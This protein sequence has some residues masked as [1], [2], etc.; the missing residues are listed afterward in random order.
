MSQLDLDPS[1][2]ETAEAPNGQARPLRLEITTNGASFSA[3]GDGD[4]VLRA[5]AEFDAKV[6]RG[7]TQPVAQARPTA[8]S[9][10]ASVAPA[11]ETA[12]RPEPVPVPVFLDR[13]KKLKSNPQIAAGIVLWAREHR[14]QDSI[15][16]DSIKQFWKDTRHKLPA[17]LPRDVS[18]AAKE[19]W[20][21][22][23]ANGQFSITGHGER[24]VREQAED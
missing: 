19:G 6:L 9:Q 1:G 20:I 21:T 24:F 7:G 22:R 18:A 16:I 15:D 14:G 11:A 10:A 5:F 4:L 3:S 2:V 23:E 17:N 13:Y 12:Q 8:E